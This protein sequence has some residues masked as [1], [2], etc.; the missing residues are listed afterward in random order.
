MLLVRTSRI[1]TPTDAGLAFAEE[2][3][4]VLA[5]FELAVAEARRAGGAGSVLRLG[6][7]PTLPIGQLVRFLGALRERSLGA[8]LQLS[9]L[10]T[11]E[12]VRR[13]RDGQLELGIF[14]HGTDYAELELEPLFAGEPLAAYLPP[15]HR[16]AAKASLGPA[17]LLDED[18][19]GCAEPA[20]PA[21]RDRVFALFDQAGYGL[22][23]LHEASGNDPRDVLLAVA[24]GS[25]I[26]LLPASLSEIGEAGA[27]VSRRPLDPPVSLPD[28]VLAWRRKPSPPL[29]AGLAAI[30]SAARDLRRED[31]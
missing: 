10:S 19:V 4:K 3:R 27:V 28:A 2:A 25:G 31:D 5:N 14:H 11:T 1:V 20:D 17:D 18:L 8:R 26:G 13:L 22:G 23:G 15:G 12:Q 9:H 16:L 7:I 29:Q 21:L 30:R 6:C 24:G